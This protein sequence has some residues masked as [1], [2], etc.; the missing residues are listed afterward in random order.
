[1]YDFLLY[2]QVTGLVFGK[3]FFLRSDPLVGMLQE[4][5]I[6]RSRPDW[7]RPNSR[8][9]SRHFA[10]AGPLPSSNLGVQA[11]RPAVQQEYPL[12]KS[13]CGLCVD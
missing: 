11:I 2:G 8:V 7:G 6:Y 12:S 4:F 1:M 10:I 13:R 3:L 5:A 9:T